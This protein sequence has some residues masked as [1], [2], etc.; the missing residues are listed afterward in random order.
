ML[1]ARGPRS[2]AHIEHPAKDGGEGQRIV[3]QAREI[4]PAGGHHARAGGCGQNQ[5]T[6]LSVAKKDRRLNGQT[7]PAGTPIRCTICH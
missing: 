2:R 1:S 3:Y 5:R 4:A 7:I 6:V